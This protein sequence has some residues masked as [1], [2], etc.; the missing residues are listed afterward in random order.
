M[1][2][3]HVSEEEGGGKCWDFLR[4][5]Y[6]NTLEQVLTCPIT[7]N[8]EG[9]FKIDTWVKFSLLASISKIAPF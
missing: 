3:F 1:S 5:F 4:K 6:K 8:L 2:D 7:P 9:E